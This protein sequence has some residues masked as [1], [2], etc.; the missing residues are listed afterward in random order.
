MTCPSWRL[1]S[2]AVSWLMLRSFLRNGRKFEHLIGHVDGLADEQHLARGE[3]AA[4][5]AGS[6]VESA[7]GHQG[8]NQ[9][10]RAGHRHV[11]RARHVGQRRWLC[12]PSRTVRTHPVCGQTSLTSMADHSAKPAAAEWIGGQFEGASVYPKPRAAA[13]AA[14]RAA[15]SISLRSQ[16]PSAVRV[17]STPAGIPQYDGDLHHDGTDFLHIAAIVDGAA[18]GS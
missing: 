18:H 11:E 5:L 4:A 6:R 8:A 13:A 2:T 7:L 16:T 1:P 3:E 17:P 14:V 10:Q 15:Q 12:L 9:R